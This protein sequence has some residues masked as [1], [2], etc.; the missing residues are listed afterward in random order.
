MLSVILCHMAKQSVCSHTQTS[1]EGR[2]LK[3]RSQ[4]GS[5][6]QRCVSCSDIVMR[7]LFRYRTT[8]RKVTGMSPAELVLSKRLRTCLDLLRPC[9]ERRTSL[10]PISTGVCFPPRVF[11]LACNFFV[12]EPISP[13]LVTVPKI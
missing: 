3:V 7:F 10:N 4:P 2:E 9:S 13:N 1:N 8:P 5:I 11:F 12:L 6:Q